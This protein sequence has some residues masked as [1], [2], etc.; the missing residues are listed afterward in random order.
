MQGAIEG[1][2]SSSAFRVAALKYGDTAGIWINA[3]N[4]YSVSRTPLVEYW[5]RDSSGG[6]EF[7]VLVSY[8]LISCD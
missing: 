2:I 4:P 8:A 7:N 1:N 6:L 5:T 3:S